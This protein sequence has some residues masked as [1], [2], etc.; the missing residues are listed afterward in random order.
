MI[1]YAFL[2]LALWPLVC[3]GDECCLG[4]LCTSVSFL[5]A[6]VAF[7]FAQLIREVWLLRIL[8]GY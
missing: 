1:P 4:L 5:S 7:I 6:V 3:C 8:R 2:A